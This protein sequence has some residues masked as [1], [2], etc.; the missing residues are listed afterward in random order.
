MELASL[1]AAVLAAPEDDKPR[2]AYADAVEGS[3]PALASF[4]RLQCEAALPTTLRSRARELEAQAEILSKANQSRWVG[5]E[6]EQLDEAVFERGFLRGVFASPLHSLE[7]LAAIL[8]RH[9]SLHLTVADFD[10]LD[11]M[12]EPDEEVCAGLSGWAACPQLQT[13]HRLGQEEDALTASGWRG[14]TGG[15]RACCEPRR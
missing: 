14:G 4:I 12:D 13:V 5:A 3:D 7:A 9:K 10:A 15:E 8:E 2:L 6:I 11:V 1:L